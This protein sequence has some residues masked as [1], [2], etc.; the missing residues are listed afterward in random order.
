MASAELSQCDVL[1][2]AR[3]AAGLFAAYD[4]A[5]IGLMTEVWFADGGFLADQFSNREGVVAEASRELGLDSVVTSNAQDE[6]AIA[7]IPVN[8]FASSIRKK[9]GWSGS[10]RIYR[11]RITPVL[12]IGNETR[13]D[14]LISRR[15]G[16]RALATV[17]NPKLRELYGMTAEKLSVD[18]V[19]PG[20]AQSMTR[21]GSLTGGVL[22][23]IVQDPRIGQTVAL[24]PDKISAGEQLLVN[25]LRVKLEYFGAVVRDVQSRGIDIEILGEVMTAKVTGRRKKLQPRVLMGFLG[26]DIP[27]QLI[28]TELTR[29]AVVGKTPAYP[30]LES[31]IPASR[32][33][34]LHLRAKLFSGKEKPPIGSAGN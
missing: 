5:R 24:V 21:A 2:V 29:A 31:A 11:D 14:R 19:A 28:S 4:C 30:G 32:E 20:L 1:V 13:L 17:V 3:D 26:L 10:W 7:G 16:D 25:Q 22:E 27:A 15:L 9:L 18:S 33:A 34:S 8:P 23:L 6:Q 12:K